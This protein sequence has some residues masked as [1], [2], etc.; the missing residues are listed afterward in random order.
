[1]GS[2]GSGEVFLRT[3]DPESIHLEKY[4][5]DTKEL[6]DVLRERFDQEKIYLLGHS[7]G[8][9]LGLLTAHR[10]PELL[11]AYISVSQIVHTAKGQELSYHFTLQRARERN[12]PEAIAELEKI[13]API[14]G[15]YT[16]PE[17][18]HVQR[19]WLLALGGERYGKTG[20]TD[21]A[22]EILLSREYSAMDILKYLK[23]MELSFRMMESIGK[24]N[25]FLDV[26]AIAVPV[27]FIAG[28]DDFNTPTPLIKEYAQRLAGPHISYKEFEKSSHSPMYEQPEEFN[29]YL[30]EIKERVEKPLEA[31]K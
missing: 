5:T 29:N 11:K 16:N 2:K 3:I 17:D 25:F 22:L 31:Q 4:L 24:M 10:H 12:I 18:V 23:G 13:K 26:K 15:N 9:A 14:Q 27:F 1:M 6:I 20:Y 28:K 19:K 8:S 21:I 7:W 30:I